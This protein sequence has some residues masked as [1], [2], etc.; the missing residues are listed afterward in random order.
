MTKAAL[1]AAYPH[2]APCLHDSAAAVCYIY[3][4]SSQKRC[5]PRA[6][7]DE[8]VADFVVRVGG[9]AICHIVAV[10]NCVLTRKGGEKCDCLVFTSGAACFVEI[11][12]GSRR[13]LLRDV[14]KGLRQVSN[15]IGVFE[16]NGLLVAGDPVRAIVST[17]RGDTIA[18]NLTT[19]RQNAVIGLKEQYPELDLDFQL[20]DEV[21]V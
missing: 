9:G 1:L 8:E 15:S 20:E 5:Y 18:P 17:K 4:H 2:C 10:D 6:V 12:R 11:K 21:T 13:N 7:G 3:E 16:A 19:F 14:K